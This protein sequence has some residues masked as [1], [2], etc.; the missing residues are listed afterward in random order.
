MLER[1]KGKKFILFVA[2]S[3]R[4]ADEEATSPDELKGMIKKL[5]DGSIKVTAIGLQGADRNMLEAI[6]ESG[7][8]RL[9]M[10]DSPKA[11]AKVFED[12]V[13]SVLPR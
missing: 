2:A 5:S 13:H 7:D 4:S 9:Y 8:G 11:L 12:E 3:S 1:L 10:V 6:A